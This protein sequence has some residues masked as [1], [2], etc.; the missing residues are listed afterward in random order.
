MLRWI[1]LLVLILILSSIAIVYLRNDTAVVTPQLRQQVDNLARQ[2]PRERLAREAV[3]WTGDLTGWLVKKMHFSPEEEVQISDRVHQALVAANQVVPT[4]SRL[5]QISQDLEKHIPQQLLPPKQKFEITVFDDEKSS[6]FASGG[7]HLYITTGALKNYGIHESAIAF[8]LAHE[9]GH[10]CRKHAHEGYR[11]LLLE[12]NRDLGILGNLGGD[13]YREFFQTIVRKTDDVIQFAYNERQDL[14]ADLF[15][16][17]LC[18]NAGLDTNECLDSL[19]L[20]VIDTSPD[21]RNDARDGSLDVEELPAQIDLAST[22]LLRRL[23]NLRNELDGVFP[24]NSEYGLMKYNSGN[25]RFEDLEQAVT[26][27]KAVIFIHGME[28]ELAHFEELLHAASNIPGN[29]QILGFQFPNDGSL[30]RAATRLKH[31]VQ[32]SIPEGT[33]VHFV[34]HSAGGLVCRFYQEVLSGRAQSIVFLGTPQHGADLAKLRALIELKQLLTS[35]SFDIP[36]TLERA[37]LDGDGQ[38]AFDLQS[39]SLFLNHLNNQAAQRDRYSIIRGRAMVE[40]QARLLERGFSSGRR[41]A[42]AS[43][44]P[45]RFSST[46]KRM[47]ETLNGISIPEEITDGDMAVSLES[48]ELDG[49]NSVQTVAMDHLKLI[50]DETVAAEVV[51]RLHD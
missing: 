3:S 13:R 10:V 47:I 19:R 26:A 30:S 44:L 29:P 8:L 25:E 32:R 43:L 5:I 27:T 50:R 42:S 15:A 45:L 9:M 16:I 6:V 23:Q 18:R 39:N 17:H 2:L 12:E 22:L 51:K 31:D 34:C 35:F 21:W 46:G 20:Q 28:S 49:V 14:Q 1:I 11:Y 4:E 33:P 38:I 7:G 36:Q 48:A 24:E 41:L 40:S 37:I